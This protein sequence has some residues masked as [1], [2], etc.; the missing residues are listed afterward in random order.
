M[1]TT[2]PQITAAQ[3]PLFEMNTIAGTEVPAVGYRGPQVCQIVGR[4]CCMI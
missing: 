1:D 4:V 2:P 3:E